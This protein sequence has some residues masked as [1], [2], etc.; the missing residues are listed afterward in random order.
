MAQQFDADQAKLLIEMQFDDFF[1]SINS[2]EQLLDALRTCINATEWLRSD[3]VYA[4]A[5]HI[6]LVARAQ[7][8]IAHQ[9][10]NAGY[11]CARSMLTD[12]HHVTTANVEVTIMAYA[13]QQANVL[14]LLE[15]LKTNESE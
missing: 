4:Q 10:T 5:Q 3:T 15:Q 6:T 1:E 12:A 9:L 2:T 14:Q 11:H 8:A 13:W 7:T